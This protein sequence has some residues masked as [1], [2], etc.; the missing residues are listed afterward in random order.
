MSS[1][2]VQLGRKKPVEIVIETDV[3]CGMKVMP[4][5]SAG[6]YFYNGKTYYFCSVGCLNRFKQTPGKYLQPQEIQQVKESA[7]VEFTCPMHPEITQIGFGMCPKCGMALEPKTFT[8][9]EDTTELDDMQRR[10]KLSL[11]L[12]LPIF[13]LSMS[14]MFAHIP[15]WSVWI[16]FILSIPVVVYC[17]FPFFE[18]GV[19][20]IKHKSPNMFTLIAIGVGTAFIYSVIAVIYPQLFP[21]VFHSHNGS[22]GVY[23]EAATVIITLVLLGQILEL[24]A[25]SQTNTALKEIL[26]LSPKNARVIFDDGTEA[27]LPID[28]LQIGAKLRVRAN[29]K[30]PIDGVI[31]SGQSSVDESMISGEAMPIF[32]ETGAKV[33]GGTFNQQ[34]SFVMQVEKIGRETLISQIVQMIGE[35]QRSKAPIQS[36]ADKVATYFV[37]S[38][39]LTA[40]LTLAVWA[41]FGNVV[42]GFVCAVA[43]LIIACPCALGLATPMSVMVGT[44]SGAKNGVLT[45][46][47]EALQML[48]KIDVLVV[49]KTGT[50]TVGKPKI[51]AI[52]P[53][54]N[55]TENEV[56][57]IAASL[58]ALSEHPLANAITREATARNLS[59]SKVENFQS[60]TGKGVSGEINGKICKIQ[61]SKLE[62]KNENTNVE[63]IVNNEVIGIIELADTI[64]TSAKETIDELKKIG[65]EI[66]MLTG[67][68]KSVA[69]FIASQIGIEKVFANVLPADKANVIKDLQ[70]QG[71]IVAMAGDGVNDAVALT[72]SN[73]GIAMA[74][75]TDIAVESADIVLI[76]GDLRGILRSINLSKAVMRNIKQNLF[77]AFAYNLLGVPL[78]AGLLYPVFGMILS[79]MIAS[80][81]MTFSSVSVIGNALRLRNAKL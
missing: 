40:I 44:G 30:I 17:G 80:L 4:E 35:A 11:V 33:I 24:R 48:E 9:A 52:K 62:I 41:F 59:F 32:K 28:E 12:T 72:Q 79:P 14:E 8:L 68:N 55:F 53:F 75:G 50:L 13:L 19:Q 65:I 2:L 7:E 29:E 27:D 39:I 58:E 36:L 54:K 1:N 64:K 67:D 78:A 43:V 56:L 20:S 23:F 47:A 45:K 6:N 5:S 18:R 25:R 77:F 21:Q 76:N 15:A 60:V 74:N 22:I 51:T 16:Q 37:P 63:V 81:A 69:D 73:V 31:L 38:V 26:Q 42:F 10:F 61:N 71:K 70:L 66:V 34:G 46:N 49:D 3:V 57:Q